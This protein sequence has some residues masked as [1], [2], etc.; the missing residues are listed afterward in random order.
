[1]SYLSDTIIKLK[2]IASEH[3]EKLAFVDQPWVRVSE[4]KVLYTYYFKSDGELLVIEPNSDTHMGKWE[5][6]S[7][8][9]SILVQD[10]DRHYTMKRR[11]IDRAIMYFWKGEDQYLFV[12]ENKVHE[13]KK[14]VI[15]FAE[16]Y[17]KE[18]IDQTEL[19]QTELYEKTPTANTFD[20]LLLDNDVTSI[21]PK[22]KAS[23][24]NSLL[25]DTVTLDDGQTFSF[26]PPLGTN[27]RCRGDVRYSV[28]EEWVCGRYFFDHA[29]KKFFVEVIDSEVVKWFKM[30]RYEQ[31]DGESILVGYC[32]FS[33]QIKIGSPVADLEG[34]PLNGVFLINGYQRRVEEGTLTGL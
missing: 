11:F 4:G 17:I 18:L 12:N 27:H 1:M 22:R 14:T 9:D 33:F 19:D 26:S 2:G 16:Q 7:N 25:I 15:A 5:L 30:F 10:E 3:S 28:N 32:M 8:I 34:N 31:P 24:K 23:K 21:T 20:P 6:L 13:A 29:S